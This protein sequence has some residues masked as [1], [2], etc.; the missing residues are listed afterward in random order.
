MLPELTRK[1]DN[2]REHTKHAKLH[3][4]YAG[5]T[6]SRVGPPRKTQNENKTLDGQVVGYVGFEIKFGTISAVIRKVKIK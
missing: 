2:F 1:Q 5:A 3:F 4:D 6:G